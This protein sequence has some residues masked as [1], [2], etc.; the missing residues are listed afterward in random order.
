MKLRNLAVVVVLSGVLTGCGT[1]GG[2]ISGAG[3]DLSK[4]GQWIKNR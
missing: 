4:A 1:L 3:E 2:A